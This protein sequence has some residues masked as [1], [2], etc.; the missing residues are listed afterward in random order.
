MDDVQNIDKINYYFSQP[1][2]EL[3]SKACDK[4]KDLLESII[5][6]RGIMTNREWH[7]RVQKTPCKND[8]NS[9]NKIVAKLMSNNNT[10]TELNANEFKV[11]W[12]VN[13]IVYASIVVWYLVSDIKCKIGNRNKTR[14]DTKPNWLIRIEKV[15]LDKRRLI[16]KCVAEIGRLQDNSRMTRKT[17]RNRK[18]MGDLLGD[19][20][21]SIYSLTKLVCKLKAQIHRQAQLRRRKL[22][23]EKAKEWNNK[24]HNNQSNVFKEFKQ[25]VEND[26]DN[27]HPLKTTNTLMTVKLF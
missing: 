8:V 10:I 2:N 9:V 24:F 16:S 17:R 22:S 19:T 5:A 7:T 25:M 11:L 1:Y 14:N 6:E 21:I 23:S 4:A 15:I 13:C 27:T 12:T 18:E 3:E 26:T 20:D